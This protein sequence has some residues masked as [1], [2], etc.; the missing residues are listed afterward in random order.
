MSYDIFLYAK[1]FLE[2][3]LATNLG[4]W[5]GAD[6]ISQPAI[7]GA[8]A[9]ARGEGFGPAQ[10]GGGSI[11]L[12]LDSDTA[13]AELSIYP[14][15]IA[16]TIPHGERA[17]KAI[18]LC[19]G[20]AKRIAEQHD[21]GFWDPQA[22]DDEEEDDTAVWIEALRSGD[23]AMRA[24]AAVQLRGRDAGLVVGPL[25]AAARHDGVEEVRRLAL[26]SLG[27]I[28]EAAARA[29]DD[30]MACLSD[31]SPIIQYW[32]T[33][34][35]GRMGPVAARAL[36]ALERLSASPEHGPRYGSLDAIRRIRERRSNG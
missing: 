9:A 16:F 17:E 32:A 3:A 7:D 14:G 26:E 2:R 30:V 19:R 27:E 5:T 23:P 18:D 34:A 15:E 8:I 10:A 20:L 11:E 4:D 21:L 13:L 24:D 36:P 31:A 33:F 22:G 29:F 1:A 28:G 12:I 35:L 6:P 25:A